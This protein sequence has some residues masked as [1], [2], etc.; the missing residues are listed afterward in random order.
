MPPDKKRRLYMLGT[1]ET[2][3][4]QCQVGAA[5]SCR[6]RM[7]AIVAR[8]W[9]YIDSLPSKCRIASAVHIAFHCAWRSLYSLDQTVRA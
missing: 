7:T 3:Y 1:I 2:K 6:N 4:Y 9:S 8:C 5:V